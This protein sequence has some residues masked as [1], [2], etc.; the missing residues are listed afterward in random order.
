MQKHIKRTENLNTF[1]ATW[2][3]WWLKL[4]C[5]KKWTYLHLLHNQCCYC[6]I[7]HHCSCH[8]HCFL[9]WI[10]HN[11]LQSDLQ[12]IPDL[13][14][15]ELWLRYLWPCLYECNFRLFSHQIQKLRIAINRVSSLLAKKLFSFWFQW[16]LFLLIVK[17]F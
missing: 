8:C 6:Q 15:M 16:Q 2:D 17:F 12:M 11:E 3:K 5:D 4:R 14:Q 10:D 9:W 1:C 7:S 13:Q